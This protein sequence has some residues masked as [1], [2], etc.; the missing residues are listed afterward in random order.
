MT[1]K[2]YRTLG[3]IAIDLV[4]AKPKTQEVKDFFQ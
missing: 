4:H 2:E 1:K 3:T